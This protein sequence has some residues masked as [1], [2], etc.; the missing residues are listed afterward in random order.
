MSVLG[1]RANEP[2]PGWHVLDAGPFHL[3]VRVHGEAGA[4]WRI[5]A[6]RNGEIEDRRERSG[7][8]PTA[9]TAKAAALA[10]ARAELV[11]GLAALRIAERGNALVWERVSDDNETVWRAGHCRVVQGVDG[12]EWEAG[13]YAGLAATLER[14]QSACEEIAGLGHAARS[15]ERAAS[16][17]G[18]R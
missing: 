17:K 14:A 3:I 2:V 8:A 12:Y 5:V 15:V 4:S 9:E 10:C 1:W 13:N 6:S 16:D 18:S 11:A 7:T